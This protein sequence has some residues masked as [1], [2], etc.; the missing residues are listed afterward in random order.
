MVAALGVLLE[1]MPSCAELVID[2]LTPSHDAPLL[3]SL[4]RTSVVRVLLRRDYLAQHE[5]LQ[6]CEGGHADRIITVQVWEGCDF[7]G[8]I[9][10]VRELA[11]IMGSNVR[12]EGPTCGYHD[13]FLFVGMGEGEGETEDDD[14]VF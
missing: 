2:D 11:A 8:C 10:K 9:V 3:P 13:F 12:V 7:D 6:W 1:G 14:P 4:T 5:L